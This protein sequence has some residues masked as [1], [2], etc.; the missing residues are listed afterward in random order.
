MAQKELEPFTYQFV[1]IS[2]WEARICCQEHFY[3]LRCCC[4]FIKSVPRFPSCSVLYNGTHTRLTSA[5]GLM[6]LHTAE[7]VKGRRK[8]PL[9]ALLSFSFWHQN[10]FS[11]ELSFV[12]WRYPYCLLAT[13]KNSIS[14]SSHQAILSLFWTLKSIG[15][16]WPNASVHLSHRNSIQML[17]RS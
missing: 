5:R 12:C 9:L 1:L 15:A 7:H 10:Y 4:Y 13:V 6:L 3:E 2:T 11:V 14:K 16:I 8:S 17:F